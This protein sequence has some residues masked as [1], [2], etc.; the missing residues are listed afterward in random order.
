MPPSYPPANPPE[1]RAPQ[2]AVVKKKGGWLRETLGIVAIALVLSV[3]IKTFFMQAFYIPSESMENTLKVNDRIMVNKMASSEGQLNRGDVVVFIDPGGWL[4]G[5][6]P[7][8]TGA[9]KVVSD[10]LSFVG[11]LPQN[12]GEHVIKR[13]VGLPGDTV[14]CCG[15]DGRISVNGEPI[16]E[17][18]LKE[19]VA[20]SEFEFEVVVPEGHLWLM[21]DN[22]SNSRD[23]R[24]H[25]GQPGGGF[26]PFDSVE[27]RAF[28]ITWPFDRLGGLGGGSDAFDHVPDP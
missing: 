14:A 9:A 2:H 22:R 6:Q 21:G 11:L 5:T 20:P 4:S 13:V 3:I 17:P 7:Q 23:S 1:Q 24:A 16:S 19:G 18:Y 15:E 27:G 8:Q 26:V 25:M 10:V 12:A 28:V